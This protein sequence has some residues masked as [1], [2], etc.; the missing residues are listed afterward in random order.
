MAQATSSCPE[1]LQAVQSPNAARGGAMT[2]L[3]LRT[4]LFIATLLTICGLTG[5]LLLI[6]RHTVS[7]ET[8]RQVRDGT[9]ASVR[10]FEGVQR[11]RERQL[12]S[13]AAML[14]DLPPLEAMMPTDDALTIQD[15]S[16]TF[17]KLAGSDLFVLA[18]P[19]KQIVALH[20]TTPGRPQEAAERDL[21]RSVEQGDD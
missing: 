10:A 2:H 20:I 13:T 4:Q 18:K 16:T 21:K 19:D 7:V 14:A 8:D 17:W 6:I 9:E 12:S 15:A 3:R 5:G 11:Q 1:H